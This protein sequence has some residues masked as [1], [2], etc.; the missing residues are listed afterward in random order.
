MKFCVS[1]DVGTWTNW[2]TSEPGLSDLDHS[3]DPG[4]GFFN[5][6]GISQ[7][8]SYG[9]ISMKF[10]GSITGAWM[11]PIRIIVRIQEP[12]LVGLHRILE[13]QRDI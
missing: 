2:L 7:E 11:N 13:F 5:F 12:G 6:S 4:A 9:Q 8:L 1:T 10:K 3:P